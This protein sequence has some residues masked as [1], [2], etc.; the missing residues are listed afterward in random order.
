[1]EDQ[2]SYYEQKLSYEM[3]SGDLF[4]TINQGKKIKVVD[5]RSKEAYRVEHSRKH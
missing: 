4:E 5:A 2:Q 3:D 1:M